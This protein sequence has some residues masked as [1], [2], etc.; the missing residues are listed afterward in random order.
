MDE[1]LTM[2][3]RPGSIRTLSVTQLVRLI[4]ETLEANLDGF[5]VA[6]EVSNTRVPPSGHLYFTLKDDR[7]SISVVM[8][9][10]DYQRLRFQV[11]DGIALMI[12]GRANLFEARGSLQ[13]IADEI[14][15]R[16]IGALQ[17]AFEQLKKRLA[18]EGLFDRERK[19]PI[20]F[21]PRTVGIVTARRGAGLRDIVRILFDRLPNLH[22]IVRP[23]RV[24]GDGAAFEIAEAIADLNEDGRADVIIVGRGGGSLEDLWAFN[25]E[26]VARAIFRSRIPVISAVGHEVDYTIA[27][28]VAD[29]RAPTPTAAAQMAVPSIENLR[30]QLLAVQAA[31]INGI[32]RELS[33]WRETVDDLTNRVRHPGVMAA[34]ARL[35][36]SALQNALNAVLRRRA[37]D[38][39]RSVRELTARLRPPVADVRDLRNQVGRMALT[40][41]HDVSG[42][43]GD[44]R[45]ALSEL[46]ARLRAGAALGVSARR[47]QLAEMAARLDSLSPLRVLER[48]YA[49]VR[50][51]RDSRV[52]V[53]S[54]SVEVGDELQIRL[55]K[56]KLR[57][58]TIAREA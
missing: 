5:W 29:V 13:I 57:A 16:G 38:A 56:G 30:E 51:Q 18:A 24:Q 53:D 52:V 42:L 58:R 26:V 9:R 3:F 37:G 55:M 6:G 23:A 28:F 35:E 11:R 12:R 4:S 50:N 33:G 49:V 19:R 36:I 10:S 43:V 8:F 46:A 14:E 32:E 47:H 22:L 39:R 2:R 1:Q 27:D 25:E 45:S 54:S 7:S 31:L 40:L 15:P 17:I 34:R 41:A 44:S 48:G 20:P 21:L